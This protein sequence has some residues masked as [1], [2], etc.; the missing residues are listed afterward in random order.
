MKSLTGQ[1]PYRLGPDPLVAVWDVGRVA[2]WRILPHRVGLD[3]KRQRL[4]LADLQGG[5]LRPWQCLQT[6]LQWE[7]ERKSTTSSCLCDYLMDSVTFA[8][9]T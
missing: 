4:D 5:E 1:D 7:K 9:R 2:R 8:S 6:Y 3:L